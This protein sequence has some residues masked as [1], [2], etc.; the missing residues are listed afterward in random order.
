[1]LPPPDDLELPIVKLLNH[2]GYQSF[3][4]QIASLS[5]FPTAYVKLLPP[6]WDTSIPADEDSGT[7]AKKELKKRIKMYVG[8]VIEAFGTRRIM[9]G[10][11]SASTEAFG[12]AGA[13][14]ELARE[15]FAE[16]AIEQE[17]IDAVFA[18]TAKKV[19]AS[20]A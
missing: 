14:Y 13:W 5:L 8:P 9:F 15:S 11:S 3:Q 20:N 19:Y 12:G 18:G 7:T 16:L 2:P 4:G 1:M 17:D 10:S 6:I